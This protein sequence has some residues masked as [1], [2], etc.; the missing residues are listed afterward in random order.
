[1]V[2]LID[3]LLDVSRISLGRL[4][5]RRSCVD[6]AAVVASAVETSRPLIESSGHELTVSLPRE[7]VHVDGDLTRLAQ[8]LVNLLSNAARYTEAGGRIRL[9]VHRDG[10]RALVRVSDDG[11]GIPAE[12]LP[13][14]FSL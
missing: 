1:M 10:E 7:P 12:M 13:H 5:L 11:I 14:L 3:D 2:R 9:S 4:E 6:L 8:V